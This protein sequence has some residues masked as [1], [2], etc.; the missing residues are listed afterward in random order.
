MSYELAK[1]IRQRYLDLV[2]SVINYPTQYDN[3]GENVKFTKPENAIWVRAEI[4]GTAAAQRDLCS[5]P[6][7]REEGFFSLTIFTPLHHG[8]GKARQFADLVRRSFFSKSVAIDTTSTVVYRTPR[9]IE[10]GHDDSGW[11]LLQVQCPFEHTFLG[12]Q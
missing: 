5:T 9:I 6:R 10:L 3:M 11:W 1:S 4:I 2:L 8:D 12:D 7:I